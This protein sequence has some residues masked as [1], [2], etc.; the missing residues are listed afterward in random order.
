[1][2]AL[3]VTRYIEKPRVETREPPKAVRDSV[4]GV[5][6]RIGLRA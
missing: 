3:G 2:K 4:R 1:M 6:P 5:E